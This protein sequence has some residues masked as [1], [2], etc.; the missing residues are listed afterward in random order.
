MRR[1]PALTRVS[2]VIV[3]SSRIVKVSN[4]DRQQVAVVV[5]FETNY[6]ETTAPNQ[7]TTWYCREQWRFT[8]N[9]DVLS[10]PPDSSSTEERTCR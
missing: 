4:L 2:G 1:P 7:S 10:K 3:A 9:R 6:T 8:R 5:E